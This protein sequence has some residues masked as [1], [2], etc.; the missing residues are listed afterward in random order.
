MRSVLAREPA[1]AAELVEPP[2]EPLLAPLVSPPLTPHQAAGLDLILEGFLL[3][4]GRPRHLAPSEPGREVLAGDYCY[5]HGLARIAEAGDLFVIEALADLIAL[6]AGIVASGGR[7]A[8][9]PL[10]RATAAA[11]A[12]RRSPQE[13]AVGARLLDAKRLLRAGGDPSGLVAVA[14]A[15]PPTPGLDEAFRP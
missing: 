10:W 3:H 13:D 15:L 7:E 12:A 14:D 1:L 8:L 4:H 11:I 2:A 9:A 5:A 6:G